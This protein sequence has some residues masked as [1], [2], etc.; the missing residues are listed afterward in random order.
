MVS[1]IRATSTTSISNSQPS[2]ERSKDDTDP[3][4]PRRP[5]SRRVTQGEGRRAQ[6][7]GRDECG[8]PAGEAEGEDESDRDREGSAAVEGGGARRGVERGAAPLLR[9]GG[10]Q[11]RAQFL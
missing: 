7:H 10:A 4:L 2:S 5:R 11:F 8:G 3:A 6:E 1:G 9:G